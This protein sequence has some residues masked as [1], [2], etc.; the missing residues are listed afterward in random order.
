[1]LVPQSAGK[2]P[3]ELRMNGTV[4]FQQGKQ[5][6]GTAVKEEAN[7]M[8]LPLPGVGRFEVLARY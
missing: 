6:Q 5:I 1:V 2:N 4:V 8:R 3:R 7:G